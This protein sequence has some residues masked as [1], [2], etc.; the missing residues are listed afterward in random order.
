MFGFIKKVFFTAVTFFSFNVLSVNFLECVSVNNQECK[1]REEIINVNTNNPMFYPFSV[2]ANK[3]SRNC[4]NI[5]VLDYVLQMLLKTL[6]LNLNALNLVSWN[7]KPKQIKLH[8]SCKCECRLNSIVCNNKQ[9]WNKDKCNCECKELV[10]KQECNKG[11][12]WN[13]SKCN[14]ECDKSCNISEYLDYKNCKCRKKAAYSLAEEC[15]KNTDKNEVIHNET[16]SIKEY[17]KSTN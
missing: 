10:E 12:I 6:L 15:D 11:F 1:V 8:K 4:N 3:C 9:K 13:P 14:C 2:K 17:N 5:H 16:L 7:N